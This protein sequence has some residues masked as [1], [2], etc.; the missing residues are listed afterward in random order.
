MNEPQKKCGFGL[1]LGFNTDYMASGGIIEC[2]RVIIEGV[3]VT[4]QSAVVIVILEV[5][6]AVVTQIKMMI[7][8]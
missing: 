7:V 6:V 3:V 5:V 1:A 8:R 2:K 4:L